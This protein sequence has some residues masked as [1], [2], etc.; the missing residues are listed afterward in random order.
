MVDFR[1]SFEIIWQITL[2]F[3]WRKLNTFRIVLVC[4]I[5]CHFFLAHHSFEQKKNFSC[6]FII[7]IYDNS[8][9]Q[10]PNQTKFGYKIFIE[11]VLRKLNL[12]NKATKIKELCNIHSLSAQLRY[13]MPIST[14]S[15]LLNRLRNQLWQLILIRTNIR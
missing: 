2:T 9:A 3:I 14:N 7:L 11:A 1:L 8:A 10:Y 5:F 4:V 6:L 15:K 13:P 12:D